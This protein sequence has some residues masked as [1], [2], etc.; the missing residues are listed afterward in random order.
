MVAVTPK[1]N[2]NGIA[3]LKKLGVG[4]DTCD[5]FVTFGGEVKLTAKAFTF[6]AGVKHVEVPVSLDQLQK[7]NA[8]T[9]PMSEKIKMSNELSNAIAGLMS[10]TSFGNAPTGLSMLPEKA[11][12][13]AQHV[14]EVGTVAKEIK[15]GA[16]Y[17]IGAEKIAK[18]YGKSPIAAALE[19]VAHPLA[20]GLADGLDAVLDAPD[21][22]AP[23]THKPKAKP[24][25]KAWAPFPKAKLHTAAPVKLRDATQMYQPVYGTSSGSRYFM[26]AA[27][28][29]MRVA[30]R[31]DSGTLS[32]RIEGPN[33]IKHKANISECGFNTIDVSKGYAS[34][35]LTVGTDMN[36]ARKTL[37]AILLGLGVELDTPIPD[38]KAV[39]N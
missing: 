17:S 33:W 4:T 36:V 23:S 7:L 32:V 19:E 9:L 38:M 14:A 3:A 39:Y 26:V 24:E 37:G 5:M 6:S 31:L 30:M 34:V 12:A 13:S 22:H 29:D 21:L 16:A 1:I 20:D 25:T 18:M 28:P 15:L 11:F 8:G 10:D 2:L 35:H 27:N